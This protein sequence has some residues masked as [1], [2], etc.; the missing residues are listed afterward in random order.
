MW[1][2]LKK[3]QVR[4][5]SLQLIYNDLI[6]KALMRNDEVINRLRVVDSMSRKARASL[7][8]RLKTPIV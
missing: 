5:T 7:R 2:G 3:D 1:S 8:P 6:K 4:A